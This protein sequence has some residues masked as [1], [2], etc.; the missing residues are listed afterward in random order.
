MKFSS[1]FIVWALATTMCLAENTATGSSRRR[2]ARKNRKRRGRDLSG[3]SYLVNHDVLDQNDEVESRASIAFGDEPIIGVYFQPIYADSN[4]NGVVGDAAVDLAGTYAPTEEDSLPMTDEPSTPIK[5]TKAGE[6]PDSLDRDFVG[7]DGTGIRKR[8]HK[9]V[10]VKRV[11]KGGRGNGGGKGK[12]TKGGG[13]FGNRGGSEC[14][15]ICQDV[16]FSTTSTRAPV[17]M[18]GSV[19]EW[20]NNPADSCCCTGGVS[21]LKLQFS[22]LFY[23][24]AALAGSFYIDT[25]TVAS[26]IDREVENVAAAATAAEADT[27]AGTGAGAKKRRGKKQGRLGRQGRIEGTAE[28][29]RIVDCNDECLQ[30]PLAGYPCTSATEIQDFVEDGSEICFLQ[31]DPVTGAP[32]FD[33]KFPSILNVIFES[34]VQEVFTASIDT[35]CGVPAVFPWAAT[36]FPAGETPMSSPMN[37]ENGQVSGYNYPIFMF[38]GG[39][40]TGSYRSAVNNPN[41]EAGYQLGLEE[42][43]CDCSAYPPTESP[44][45][46]GA[47]NTLP[48]TIDFSCEPTE[49]GGD[50]MRDADGYVSQTEE[51]PSDSP[52]EPPSAS[53]SAGPTVRFQLATPTPL[54]TDR[55]TVPPTPSP[56]NLPTPPPTGVPT[57]P[58][59]PSPT[60]APTFPPTSIPT[61]RPTTNPPT[62]WPTREPTSIPTTPPTPIPTALP[63]VK[64]SDVPSE[65]PTVVVAA[66]VD[67]ESP[68]QIPTCTDAPDG[69][70]DHSSVVRDAVLPNT[71]SR[72]GAKSIC[73]FFCFVSTPVS[74]SV[75]HSFLTI[76]MAFLF[77]QTDDYIC[78]VNNFS[79][80]CLIIQRAGLVELMS[81]ID[82]SSIQFMTLFAPTNSGCNSGGLNPAKINAMDPELLR[83]IVMTHATEGMVSAESLQCGAQL[84]TL[85]G[86]FSVHATKC[87]A[88]NHAK[89]QYGFFNDEENYPMILSPNDLELC[90]GYIQPVNNMVRVINF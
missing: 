54:P 81:G 75:A 89:A 23:T 42:C 58:P 70:M 62:P 76:V 69:S 90:N 31:I 59:T 52:S 86:T 20:M 71:C 55:P 43:G 79:N 73:K 56:T 9:T 35:S 22:T 4:F 15:Q 44:T 18:A 11:K 67:S 26:A 60:D 68:S 12:G 24:N 88:T 40:S 7:G 48:P 63:T 57:N 27:G 10:V 32:R 28:D 78:S 61:N 21:Y 16:P 17:C 87:F 72:S 13:G 84:P 65:L 50:R 85:E 49:P 3:I 2:A 83:H 33:W 37:I 25:A 41:K 45:A 1:S 14:R 30:Y 8:K 80:F 5:N 29:I 19:M 74:D 82:G 46:Y 6:I 39:M 47:T 36:A 66:A 38:T 53:A 51:R 77:I 64:A 34:T